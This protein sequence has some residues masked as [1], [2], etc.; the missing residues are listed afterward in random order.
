MFQGCPKYCLSYETKVAD[1]V[2]KKST[3]MNDMSESIRYHSADLY[4]KTDD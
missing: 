1:H 3:S 2:K 4:F